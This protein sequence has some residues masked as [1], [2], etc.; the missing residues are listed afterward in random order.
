M[1]LSLSHGNPESGVVIVSIPDL[2]SISYSGMY[3]LYCVNYPLGP[4][5][6]FING[7]TLYLHSQKNNCQ[8]H[9]I[10]RKCMNIMNMLANINQPQVNVDK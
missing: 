3:D 2:C 4:L 8:R 10:S 5:T 1:T 9:S 7:Q 6:I